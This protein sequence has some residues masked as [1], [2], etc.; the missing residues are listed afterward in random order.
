MTKK[1]YCVSLVATDYGAVKVMAEN[2]EEAK[3]LAYTEEMNGNAWW[4]NRDIVINE[5]ELW[6]EKK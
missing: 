3:E 2:E 4:N 5:V 6:D 1:L